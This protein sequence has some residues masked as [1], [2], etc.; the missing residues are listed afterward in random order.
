[1]TVQARFR[2]SAPT[3]RRMS[4]LGALNWAFG[5]EMARVEF[6]EMGETAGSLRVGVDPIWVMIQRGQL[7]TKIDG[8][9]SSSPA[10]DAEVIASAVANLPLEW[11]GRSMASTVASL[12]R[13]GRTPDWMPNARPLVVP[14]DMHMNQHGWTARTDDA[15]RYPGGWQPQPRRGRKGRIVHEPVLCCPVRVVNTASQIAAARRRYLD[16]IGALIWLH[17]DLRA[18]GILTTIELSEEFPPMAPWRTDERN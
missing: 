2:R 12:A 14:V 7:G 4:I 15:R 1:M 3:T 10:D 17:G 18:T 6:D 9:G 11:G 5:T 8:G 16:W 13:A